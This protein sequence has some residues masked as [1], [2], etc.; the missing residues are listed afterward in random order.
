[1]EVSLPGSGSLVFAHEKRNNDIN[2]MSDK[3]FFISFPP[4]CESGF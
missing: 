2:I 4:K 1:M 3:D